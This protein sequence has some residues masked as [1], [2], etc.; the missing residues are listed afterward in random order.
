MIFGVKSSKFYKFSLS[1]HRL[2]YYKH[3]IMKKS[4]ILLSSLMAVTAIAQTSLKSYM[5]SKLKSGETY[6]NGWV[7]KLVK[8]NDLLDLPD[9]SVF[10]YLNLNG[11]ATYYKS[12]QM[13]GIRTTKKIFDVD[14]G[15]QLLIVG[16]YDENHRLLKKENLYMTFDN[17]YT[18]G[19]L[20]DGFLLWDYISKKKGFVKVMTTL[21]PSGTF[22]LEMQ[23]LQNEKDTNEDYIL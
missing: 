6:H 19:T 9:D 11:I 13:M 5:Q 12:N 15:Q 16:Y 23:C 8:G 20:L 17:D 2:F 22:E 7:S 18:F 14:D 1:L 3:T 21:Y 10:Q 4:I